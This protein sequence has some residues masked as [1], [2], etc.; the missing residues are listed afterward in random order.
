MAELRERL[1]TPCSAVD[2]LAGQDVPLR[3]RR[4]GRAQTEGDGDIKGQDYKQTLSDR[5]EAIALIM[6]K[7]EGKSIDGI[8]DTTNLIV[9]HL[10]GGGFKAAEIRRAGKDIASQSRTAFYRRMKGR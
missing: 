9:G 2:A 10:I 6:K 5:M 3:E 7:H 4:L 1:N 8:L